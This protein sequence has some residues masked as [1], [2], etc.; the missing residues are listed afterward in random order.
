[1][2]FRTY[3]PHE[4]GP[5]TTDRYVLLRELAVGTLLDSYSQ[6]R[7]KDGFFVRFGSMVLLAPQVPVAPR[8]R[9][10]NHR[11]MVSTAFVHPDGDFRDRLRAEINSVDESMSVLDG[12]RGLLDAGRYSF[13]FYMRNF[14]TIRSICFAGA[15]LSIGRA[16]EAG[17]QETGHIA[18]L[19]LGELVTVQAR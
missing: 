8:G 18:E 3:R 16:D 17:R 6:Y 10:L 7:R 14:G 4:R 5:A 9:P 12:S 2:S 15:G 19:A 13:S 1:M 11:E